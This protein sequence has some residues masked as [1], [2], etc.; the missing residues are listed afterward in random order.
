MSAKPAVA[1]AQL[2]PQA[3]GDASANKAIS[4]L[5]GLDDALKTEP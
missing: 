5:Q 1:A 3:I 4:R 2:S